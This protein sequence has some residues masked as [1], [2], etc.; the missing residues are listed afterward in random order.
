[1][2]M[3]SRARH[4]ATVRRSVTA[5]PHSSNRKAAAQVEDATPSAPDGL[6]RH[7]LGR[8]SA[9]TAPASD[10]TTLV[11]SRLS[12]ARPTPWYRWVRSLSVATWASHSSLSWGG[13][14]RSPGATRAK[15]TRPFPR[16]QAIDTREIQDLAEE[17][18]LS[19]STVEPA[20]ALAR[21]ARSLSMSTTGPLHT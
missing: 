19:V 10:R 5:L 8:P 17:G 6:A 15:G 3:G 14:P 21:R 12:D 11:S 1:M 9:P 7:S 20:A 18:S 13:R 2:R 16:L 4:C